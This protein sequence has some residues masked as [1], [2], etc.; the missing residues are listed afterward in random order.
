MF[1][2]IQRHWRGFN[3]QTDY[4]TK[5]L[6]N[7]DMKKDA[8]GARAITWAHLFDEDGEMVATFKRGYTMAEY[9]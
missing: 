1:T 9:V 8:E 3:Y 6:F 7:E 5:E 4:Q 2:S